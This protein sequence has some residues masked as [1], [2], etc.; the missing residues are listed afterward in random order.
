MV[1]VLLKSNSTR[2]TLYL[3]CLF[4]LKMHFVYLH[5]IVVQIVRKKSELWIDCIL[6]HLVTLAG[7]MFL[8][9]SKNYRVILIGK[10]DAV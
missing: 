7:L 9:R 4:V 3:L 8:F 10:S 5:T 1:C 6:I 2:T